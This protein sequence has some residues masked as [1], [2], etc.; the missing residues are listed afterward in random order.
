MSFDEVIYRYMDHLPEKYRSQPEW[1][2]ELQRKLS[3]SFIETQRLIDIRG[4]NKQERSTYYRHT[5]PISS[6]ST[7]R[8]FAQELSELID[9]K[10]RESAAIS[11]SLD[12]TFP[13]RLVEEMDSK[14]SQTITQEQLREKL[15]SLEEKRSRLKEV[16]L[17]KQD[18]DVPFLPTQEMSDATKTVLAVYTQDVEEKLSIFDATEAK[19]SLFKEIINQRFLYK[20]L[21]ISSERGFS[22][23]DLDGR[24]LPLT[25]LS[26]GE[27]HELVLLFQLLFKVN[28][29]ALI[30]IDEPELSLHVAWQKQFLNDLEQITQLASFDVVIAT[31]SPQIIHDRWDL[32]IELKGPDIE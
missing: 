20:K 21:S 28:P 8:Q 13:V 11:Q 7:V 24:A 29:G 6:I 12:R 17:L 14:S 16:G 9:K 25:A 3:I 1:F 22:F 27:Q 18:E 15:T 30:L 2:T 26:S 31:H 4:Y 32:T 23:A 10:L 19:I 5:S